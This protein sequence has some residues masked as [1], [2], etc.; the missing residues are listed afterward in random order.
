MLASGPFGGSSMSSSDGRRPRNLTAREIEVYELVQRG[1]SNIEIGR[2][3][4][5]SPST[6][7]NHVSAVLRKLD[8]SNRTEAAGMNPVPQPREDAG[9]KATAPDAAP[10][11]AVMQLRSPDG[12]PLTRQLA[13]GIVDDLITRL[14]RRWYPVIARCSTFSFAGTTGMDART[15]GAQLGARYLVEG[16]LMQ[17]GSQLRLSVQLVDVDQ[18]MIEWSQVY[19]RPA[20]KVFEVID[21]LSQAVLEGVYMATVTHVATPLVSS[22]IHRLQPWQIAICGMWYYWRGTA[23]HNLRAR[24]LF[25]EALEAEPE[26]RLALYGA[27]LTYQREIYEQWS[28]DPTESVSGL[29]AV[30]KTFMGRW[31]EDA[32]ALLMHAYAELY[33]GHRDA[34][35]ET[36]QRALATEPSSLGGRSLYGQLLA[37]D[38]QAQAAVAELHKA[39]VLSP[40]TPDR[41][42][43]ECVIA[44]AHFAGE[45]YEEAVRWGAKAARSSRA[46]AMAYG[47]LASSYYFLGDRPSARSF[48]YRF[49]EL[50]PRFS[51]DRFKPMI[52]STRKEIA[53]RYLEG[54]SGA[55]AC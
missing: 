51:N 5:I 28:L 21:D 13:D 16:S 9:L 37:M 36:V 46:G 10:A 50:A 2:V 53:A 19:E 52:A 55:A 45:N 25:S 31:P 23:Q 34:A 30:A 48:A 6:A 47:V 35:I 12:D 27:A 8:V 18:G 17:L 4:K 11:I 7:K 26:Q 20:A 54:L 15:I 22:G 38:G 29:E 1:C 32:W 24:A 33:R 39:L 3:L 40:C 49:K 42:V 14:S 44:L 43:Q 41:W